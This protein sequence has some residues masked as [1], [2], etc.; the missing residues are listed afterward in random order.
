MFWKTRI[1]LIGLIAAGL[2][3]TSPKPGF[4][5]PMPFTATVGQSS[6]C[7]IVVNR[8]GTLVPNGAG[9]VL[10]S[11]L[12][13]GQSG[14]ALVTPQN[15]IYT[16][17]ANHY[18]IWRSGPEP[19]NAPNT[20]FQ[21][22]HSGTYRGSTLYGERTTPIRLRAIRNTI[23]YLMDIDLVATKD[24]GFSFAQ[25]AYQTEVAVLCE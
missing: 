24:P 3:A 22:S 15:G 14:E 21:P 12:A 17:S 11:K 2:L 18:D 10:S 1:L 5:Q 25:G 20:T 4:S 6:S 23:A 16:V 9:T 8:N 7:T 13:G 19:L